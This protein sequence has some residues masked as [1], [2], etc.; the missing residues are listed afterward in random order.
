MK[1]LKRELLHSAEEVKRIQ[2]VPLV[3]G[4]F[5]EMVDVHYGIVCSTAG[6]NYY[7]RILSTLD[8][9]RLKPNSSVA[10]HRSDDTTN[11]A[12]LIQCPRP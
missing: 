11:T 9:E 7:V 1:F 12:V 8:R 2:S 3:I 6:S 4:Q 5:L 10:L